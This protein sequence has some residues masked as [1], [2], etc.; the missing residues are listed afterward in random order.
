MTAPATAPETFRRA[1]ESLAALRPRPEIELREMRAPQRLA[2][3]S[4]AW[5]AEVVSPAAGPDPEPEVLVTGRLVLLHDP[6]GQ[7]AWDGTLRLVTF[8]RAELDPEHAN[9]PMLPEVAWSWLTGAL[10]ESAAPATAVG[11]TVTQTSSVR[12]GDI[13]GPAQV[14]DLEL[15]ASWTPVPD[16]G[17]V[18]LTEHGTAFTTVLATAAGLPP[19]GV[20]SLGAR[21]LG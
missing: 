21:R 5:S 14:C 7:E 17:P 15:R 8:V 18:D 12:F 6:E 20:A 2:P 3:W 10:E 1:V 16:D 4:A 19:V 9:D 11:G 13:S